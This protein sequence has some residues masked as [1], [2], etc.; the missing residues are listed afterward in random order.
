[1]K[2][3]SYFLVLILSLN[4]FL[5]CNSNHAG[6]NNPPEEEKIDS[7][8]TITMIFVG[9]I[10]GHD[11]QISAA[12]C[13]E[14]QTYDYVHCFQYVK[15]ILSEFDLA[16]GN[17]EV[18]LPGKAPYAGYPQFKSPDALAY[19]LKDAGFDVMVTANNHSNDGYGAAL[20]HT[21]DTLRGLGFYQTGTFKNIEERDSLYPL[22]IE[23]NG[24]KIAVLN[25]TYGTNGIPDEAPTVVNMINR[26]LMGKDI[27]KAKS[28]EPDL[29]IALMHW[30]D[31]YQLIENKYQSN[32]AKFLAEN[33]VDLI[34]G[35]HPHVLQPI[36]YVTSGESD[37]VLTVYS[38][39]NYISNQRRVNTDGGM[40]FE[41]S[42]TK[43]IFTN[44]I[45]KTDY[46]HHIVWRY[47]SPI[48]EKFPEGRFFVI[49]VAAYEAELLDSLTLSDAD[50][51]AMN[52]FTTRMRKHMNE[53]SVSTE[54]LY[55]IEKEE[56]DAIVEKAPAEKA[57]ENKNEILFHV[58]LLA[59]SQPSMDKFEGFFVKVIEI[60]EA[61]LYKYLT[62]GYSSREEA[63]KIIPQIKASGY[64][65]SFIVKYLGNTRVFD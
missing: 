10:M 63:E 6:K 26:D 27:E 57:P 4:L 12:W 42:Y 24:F 51:K 54:R 40:M 43:N 5:F 11:R 8:A 22:L 45:K 23:E 55:K 61:N 37:S 62:I 39:G 1:M 29:I 52:D 44:E 20:I 53:N 41:I 21:I 25:Y 47:R 56:E 13:E 7:F 34:I 33:G 32:N 28:L 46:A 65:D 58:Q 48:T 2:R 30:G 19:A 64:D 15:P 16:F 35:S 49:P 3:F 14:T 50:V 36:K 38:L 60:K 18:T 9:D 31:E 59:T 17:L